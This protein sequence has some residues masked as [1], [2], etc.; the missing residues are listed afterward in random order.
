MAGYCGK[1]AG[2]FDTPWSDPAGSLLP[3]RQKFG[4]TLDRALGK[5]MK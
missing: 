3:S 2:G 4:V 5:E 1:E